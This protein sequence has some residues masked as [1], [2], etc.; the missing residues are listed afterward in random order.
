MRKSR[1]ISVPSQRVL[2]QV[3]TLSEG[4]RSFPHQ[5]DDIKVKWML[6]GSIVWWGATVLRV[7][8][9]AD[10]KSCTGEILY[11]K[12]DN[13][14]RESALVRFTVNP[15][16]DER[17]LHT[18]N[19][20]GQKLSKAGE[21]SSWIFCDDP[22]PEQ[23][24]SSVSQ[25][26][27]DTNIGSSQQRTR[28][29]YTA[30]KHG[31]PSTRRSPVLPIS[32]TAS[33]IG[34]IKRRSSNLTRFAT[35]SSEEYLLPSSELT[36]SPKNARSIQKSPFRSR[37]SK[38][39]R[40]ARRTI[41]QGISSQPNIALGNGLPPQ[42]S[43]RSPSE[44]QN[45]VAHPHENQDV[46]PPAN[47][48]HN[49]GAHLLGH[50]AVLNP[51]EGNNEQHSSHV[52]NLSLR[53]H[54]LELQLSQF[55]KSPAAPTITS[56]SLIILLSL[57]WNLMK[58]LE[59]P[60]KEVNTEG[61]S[62]HGISAGFINVK[63]DCDHSTFREIA[64]YLAWRNG[65]NNDSGDSDVVKSSRTSF[66][67]SVN[68]AL[69]PSLGSD[70]VF[71]TFTVLTDITD[72]LGVNDEDDF[73][74][75]L[76]KETRGSSTHLVQV[77]G[78][79][80]TV[81]DVN[82]PDAST[83]SNS[84][85][86]NNSVQTSSSSNPPFYRV[87]V[88]AAPHDILAERILPKD[89][90][91]TS[92]DKLPCTESGSTTY[93]SVLFEQPLQNFSIE[94][95]SYRAKWRARL[96]TTSFLPCNKASMSEPDKTRSFFLKWTRMKGPSLTKWSRDSQT[97]TNSVPGQLHLSLPVVCCSSQSYSLSVSTL[98]DQHVETFM[99]QRIDIHKS[100]KLII[101]T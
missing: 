2:E 60:L 49:D 15:S 10:G 29:K 90:E 22:I 50:E 27:S 73:E 64:A 39:R 101:M 80:S 44:T 43:A 17:L 74:Q 92:T 59:R 6:H 67:P 66:I 100:N 68:R 11:D 12:L 85:D 81:R 13:Y 40:E 7:S 71:I 35:D 47:D 58:R 45:D 54:L 46:A 77:V 78:C 1:R 97:L 48:N 24:L 99:D 28:N 86:S 51:S 69:S 32:K 25:S 20:K 88:G 95:N 8:A 37:L 83:S 41:T 53:V 31:A 34:K 30:T 5:C 4:R 33:K 18:V 57:K 21:S 16:T 89:V 63:C 61:R 91:T 98:L 36:S 38:E 79:L 93:S 23:S 84:S 42:S 76:S 94:R 65:F 9:D 14:D 52:N 19:D 70:N 82:A 75:I 26:S 62:S 55:M 72:L 56:S 3:S 87:F 96:V